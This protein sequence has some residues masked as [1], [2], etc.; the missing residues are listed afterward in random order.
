VSFKLV[1]QL[2]IGALTGRNYCNDCGKYTP[3][4]TTYKKAVTLYYIMRHY[5][6]PRDYNSVSDAAVPCGTAPL[7]AVT[8]STG[9]SVSTSWI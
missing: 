6:A 5:K 7:P 1:S 2:K 8:P 3:Y 4:I 9:Q